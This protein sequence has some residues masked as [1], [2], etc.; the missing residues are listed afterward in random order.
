MRVSGFTFVRSGVELGY[1]FVPSI[2]SLLPLCDELIVNVP[3][4]T[5]ATRARVAAIA[6]ARIRV[7]DT[8]WDGSAQT[9]GVALSHHTNLALH[10]CTGDWCIYVQADEVIHEASVPAMKAAMAR[11]LAA[12]DVDGLLVHYTHLYGSYH[13]EAYGPGWYDREVRIVRRDSGARS[14]GDAQGF[15]LADGRKLRVRDSGGRYFHYGHALRPDLAARKARSLSSLYHDEPD[16]EAQMRARPPGFYEQDQRARAFTGSHPRVM[17]DI[18][19]AADW[20]YVPRTPLI[21]FRRKRFW[22]DIAYLVKTLTGLSI[23]IHRNFRLL[24]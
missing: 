23:G 4:S 21:R 8:D 16:V 22:R 9:C 17:C 7:I 3:R 12:P 20:T 5:D 10:E 14:V 15:R 18:V 19:A 1:P 6:D 2:Q 13:T 24:R 11:A